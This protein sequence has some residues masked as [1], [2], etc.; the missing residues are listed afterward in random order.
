MPSPQLHSQTFKHVHHFYVLPDLPNEMP[1]QNIIDAV[2]V[3]NMYRLNERVWQEV[4]AGHLEAASTR[5]R[6][7]STRLLEAGETALAQQAQQE[8][9]LI[10]SGGTMSLAGR[11]KLKY[12]TRALIDKSK[13]TDKE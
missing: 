12:G 9:A 10:A 1:A 4:E 2:R 5:M 6:H 11:K 3:M 8:M 13:Q 7:L